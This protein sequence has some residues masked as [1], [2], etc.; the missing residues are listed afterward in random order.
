VSEP[1][2]PDLD[3]LHGEEPYDASPRARRCDLGRWTAKTQPHPG[4][5]PTAR[6]YM[7][8]AMQMVF[9]RRE[10]PPAVLRGIY[11]FLA[12]MRLIGVVKDP[13]GRPGS[14]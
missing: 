13:L 2:L 14:S 1:S 3:G 4:S 12:G 5:Q 10:T 7:H 9:D 8:T 11:D 6:D